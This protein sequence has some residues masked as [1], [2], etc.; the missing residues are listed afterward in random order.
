MGSQNSEER[1]NYSINGI[2]MPVLYMKKYMKKIK[3][4]PFFMI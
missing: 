3:L 4:L 2:E 1:M